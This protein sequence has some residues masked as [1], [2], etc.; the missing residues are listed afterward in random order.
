MQVQQHKIK[1]ERRLVAEINKLKRSKRNLR[2]SAVGI[3][4]AM[5]SVNTT[6]KAT[7]FWSDSGPKTRSML[8]LH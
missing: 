6:V 7:P 2:Y 1:D 4:A 8:Y 3:Q 5:I